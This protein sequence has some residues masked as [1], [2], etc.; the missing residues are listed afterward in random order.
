MRKRQQ[1]LLRRGEAIP[2]LGD[3]SRDR[4]KP[5]QAK[6]SLCPYGERVVSPKNKYIYET[7]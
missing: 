7:R 6:L 4:A 1:P 2:S 3:P 5:S